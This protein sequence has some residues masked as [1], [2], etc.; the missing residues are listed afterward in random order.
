MEREIIDSDDIT[1]TCVQAYSGLNNNAETQDAAQVKGQ[2]DSYWV[3]CTPSGGTQSV[4]LKLQGEWEKSYSD[5]MLLNEI[6]A[7]QE[8]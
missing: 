6:Q 4:R 7:Q 3:V 2:E 8:V 1:W 5:E